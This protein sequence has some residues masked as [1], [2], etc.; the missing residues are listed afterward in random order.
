MA[1]FYLLPASCASHFRRPL[2]GLAKELYPRPFLV[3]QTRGVSP[4]FSLTIMPS[5][6]LAWPNGSSSDVC[7]LPWPWH[8]P[9]YFYSRCPRVRGMAGPCNRAGP[10]SANH[11][12]TVLLVTSKG[13]F[14]TIG[15][16]KSAKYGHTPSSFGG[17]GDLENGHTADLAFV[18]NMSRVMTRIPAEC[19]QC[20]W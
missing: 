20:V 9:L 13:N 19:L 17:T 2:R 5:V 6:H 18:P 7:G 1:D 16:F 14:S 12:S 3:T 11:C 15:F 10:S 4:R 8:R